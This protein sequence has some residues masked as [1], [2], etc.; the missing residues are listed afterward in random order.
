MRN[1][2]ML[3]LTSPRFGALVGRFVL[4]LGADMDTEDGI[5]YRNAETYLKVLP[6]IDL[7]SGMEPEQTEHHGFDLTM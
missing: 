6:D 2:E 4:Y 7:D 1:E 5:A 3:D